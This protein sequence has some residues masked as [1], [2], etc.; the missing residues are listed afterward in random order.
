MDHDL[1]KGLESDPGDQ[2]NNQLVHFLESEQRDRA[3]DLLS[4]IPIKIHE[5]IGR[6][7]RK[8]PGNENALSS[9]G[10]IYH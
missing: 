3:L 2:L 8:P 4:S 9:S 6:F 7:L 5:S 1:D 10:V